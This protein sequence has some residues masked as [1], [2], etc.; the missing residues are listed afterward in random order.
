MQGKIE[1]IKPDLYNG[2]TFYHVKIEGNDKDYAC[3]QK[4]IATSKVG[5][6]IEFTDELKNGRWRL[7]IA[8][9]PGALRS[10]TAK[11][12]SPEEINNQLK[13]FALSYAKDIV[14]SQVRAGRTTFEPDIVSYTTIMAGMFLSWLKKSE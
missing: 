3:W 8:A 10:Y 6:T 4:G 11:T 13:S 12:K 1:V 9:A 14:A 5:D 2:I 7:N